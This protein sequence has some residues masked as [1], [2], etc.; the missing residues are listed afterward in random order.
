MTFRDLERIAVLLAALS[1]L[2]AAF[3]LSYEEAQTPDGAPGGLRPRGDAP[4]HGPAAVTAS[5]AGVSGTPVKTASTGGPAL[6]CGPAYPSP[7]M[8][9]YADSPRDGA[10]AH[11]GGARVHPADGGADTAT[12]PGYRGADTPRLRGPAAI[13]GH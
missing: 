9:P 2:W 13:Y 11:A 5:A 7:G 4:S 3:I 8:G 10:D 6:I 12:D 1:H